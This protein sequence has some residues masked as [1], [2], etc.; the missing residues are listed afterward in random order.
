MTCG[1]GNKADP[2]AGHLPSLRVVEGGEIRSRTRTVPKD[3]I[4]APWVSKLHPRD[5]GPRVTGT[6]KKPSREG[7]PKGGGQ[8][9]M[10]VRWQAEAG[11]VTPAKGA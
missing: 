4:P 10:H 11:E 3:P 1:E 8:E 6:S 2:E 9:S 5:T 7:T